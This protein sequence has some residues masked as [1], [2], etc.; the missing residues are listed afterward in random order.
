VISYNIY[1]SGGGGQTMQ[2]LAHWYKAP[3][4]LHMADAKLYATYC[5][6]QKGTTALPSVAVGRRT[7]MKHNMLCSMFAEWAKY[8]SNNACVCIRRVFT[9]DIVRSL[10]AAISQGRKR[11]R[12]INM[13]LTIKLN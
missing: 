8:R 11:Y 1:L 2:T 13:N 9:Y 10:V 6:C 3:F 5:C 12:V 4:T 7:A